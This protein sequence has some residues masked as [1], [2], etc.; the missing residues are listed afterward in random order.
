MQAESSKLKGE[1]E[2]KLK[3]NKSSKVCRKAGMPGCWE[4]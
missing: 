3:A 1:R 2:N 4:A